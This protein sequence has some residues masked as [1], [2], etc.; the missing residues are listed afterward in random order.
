MS[1]SGHRQCTPCATRPEGQSPGQA[2]SRQRIARPVRGS[3]SSSAR[4][5]CSAHST[6]PPSLHYIRAVSL[7]S[8][9]FACV[10]PREAQTIPRITESLHES[11]PERTVRGQTA[12]PRHAARRLHSAGHGAPGARTAVPPIVTRVSI[13]PVASSQQALSAC[14]TGMSVEA[15]DWQRVTGY[16]PAARLLQDSAWEYVPVHG[17]K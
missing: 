5:E 1:H 6:Q 4:G 11:D 14:D 9:R 8:T 12:S 10:L 16:A 2:Q 3:G 17:R 15:R 7:P 13:A